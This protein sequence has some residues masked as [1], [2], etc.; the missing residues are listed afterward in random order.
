[1]SVTMRMGPILPG[2][3]DSLFSRRNALILVGLVLLSFNLRPAAVSVG[4]VLAEVRRGLDMNGATTGLLTSLPVLAFACFGAVA[5]TLAARLGVHRVTLV[6]LLAVVAGLGARAVAPGELTFLVF[7]MLALAGMAMAN[8]LLPSLV[9]RHFPDHVGAATAIYTGSLSIGLTAALM[10]TVPIS[11]AAGSWRWGLGAWS[12]LALAAAIP[13]LVLAGHDRALER[14]P[15]EVRLADVARTRLGLGMALAF[16]LQSMQ[17]YIIF[18]WFA[19]LWR[20]A[21]YSPTQ[22]GLLVGLVAATSIPLSLWLPRLLARSSRPGLVLGSVV[23]CYPVAYLGLAVAPH[24]LAILWAV[25]TGA[26]TTTFPLVLTLIGLR[27]HSAGG[28]AALSGFTQ[29]AGYLM[30][31]LGPFTVGLLYDATD[32]WTVPLLLITLLSLPLL[33]VCLYVARPAYVE[34]Q[35]RSA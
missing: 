5:P 6:A 27:A 10:A 8:V 20:D 4:P 23:L 28:T 31:A 25:V 11:E 1:M 34:D 30:A 12:L 26:A 33:L 17:A 35:L 29:S 18:G 13:W 9:K 7:S 16:G 19:Q 3:M 32:G 21:G 24:D 15:Q 2:A 22:A 14:A